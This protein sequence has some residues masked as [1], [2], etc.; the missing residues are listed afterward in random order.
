MQKP[1]NLFKKVE[2]CLEKYEETR[3]SDI[4]LTIKLWVIFYRD[5]LVFSG[6]EV[7]IRLNSLWDLPREDHIKRDRARIQH[8]EGRFLPTIEEVR[9]LRGI[10]EEKWRSSLGYNPEMR[11]VPETMNKEGGIETLRQ[12]PM[13]KEVK[14][15]KKHHSDFEK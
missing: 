15:I 10:E 1:K 2:H 5:F 7:F 13:F 6:S 9:K 11:A 4:T 12:S 8:E 3:N 14:P